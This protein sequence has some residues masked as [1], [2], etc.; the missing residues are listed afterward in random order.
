MDEKADMIVASS[1]VNKKGAILSALSVYSVIR[2]QLQTCLPPDLETATWE[3][4]ALLVMGILG[5]KSASP[6]R[7][8]RALCTLGLVGATVESTERR[9]R[10][11]ENDPQITAAVCLHPLARHH[12]ALGRPKQLLLILDPTTQEDRLVM[13]SVA[14]WYRGRALPLGWAVW[15]GNQMLEGERFWE[16]V[17]AL[18]DS[19]GP[20][21]P[22]RRAGDLV[23]G[24]GLRHSHLSGS[25]AGTGFPLC[26]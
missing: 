22:H 19:V 10:R 18:L 9:I 11:I 8:A 21:L 12:L 20:L 24:S 25:V 5:A 14:V 2:D 23:G 3:R 17:Q 13:L 1:R 16:R 6:A 15:P 26:G 7:I 4:L